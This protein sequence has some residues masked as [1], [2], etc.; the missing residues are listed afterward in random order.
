MPATALDRAVPLEPAWV[1]VYASLYVFVLLPLLVVR[2][3]RLFRRTLRA[4][5]AVFLVA[6][7]GFLAYPTVAPRVERADVVGFAAWWLQLI[8]SLDSECNCFPCL[9]VAHSLV[10]ALASWRVNR[11]V[12]A[13]AVGWAM[14]IGV[15]TLF[16]K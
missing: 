8:Y 4:W 13:A 14:L 11:G 2:D 12:G 1:V 16:T 3:D 15:S 9:H 6:S 5:I 7:V 10:S